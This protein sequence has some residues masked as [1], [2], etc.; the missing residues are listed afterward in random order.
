[1]S[2]SFHSWWFAVAEAGGVKSKAVRDPRRPV[3]RLNGTEIG[4]RCFWCCQC[5][6]RANAFSPKP[7]FLGFH[8][9]KGVAFQVRGSCEDKSDGISQS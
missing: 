3:M 9:R 4:R 6:A 2:A 7:Y 5:Q 1:M 8:E